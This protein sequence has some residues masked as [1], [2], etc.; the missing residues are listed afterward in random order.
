[1]RQGTIEELEPLVKQFTDLPEVIDTLR[2]LSHHGGQMYELPPARPA[3]ARAATK[4]TMAKAKA[5]RLV[6][7]PREYASTRTSAPRPS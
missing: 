1:M 5:Q 4:Q 3:D 2:D 7:L 6:R